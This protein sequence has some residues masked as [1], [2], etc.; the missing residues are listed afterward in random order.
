MTKSQERNKRRRISNMIEESILKSQK[1][2]ADIQLKMA[3]NT[4]NQSDEM[5][6]LTAN[7]SLMGKKKRTR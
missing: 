3:S 1:K 2:E 4:S 5:R 6:R 7:I